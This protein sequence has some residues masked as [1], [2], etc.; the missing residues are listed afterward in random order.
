[1]LDQ[2]QTLDTRL[3]LLI[4]GHHT[5]FWDGVLW[6]ASQTFTWVPFYTALLVVLVCSFGRRA[7]V[8]VPLIAV[9]IL[10]SDQLASGLLKPWAHRLRP[11]HAPGLAE[12]LHLLHGYRGGPYGFVSSHAG[13]VFALAFYLFF[14]ARH[15]LP[16]LA[17]V[18]FPWAALVAY[19]RVYLGVHYP[20][21]VL[22]PALLSVPLA[23][24]VGRLYAWGAA[25]WVPLSSAPYPPA[26]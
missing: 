1:M 19:S 3:L 24:G 4:N 12:Q 23:Y 26:A 18:L 21:D 25:R 10:A 15:R 20:S 11:S 14:T 16:W 2:L 8:L 22:V 9:L 17:W 5:P 7:W 13:N 6:W